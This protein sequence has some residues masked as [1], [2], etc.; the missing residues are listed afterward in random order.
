MSELQGE[1]GNAVTFV[2]DLHLTRIF[3][4]LNSFYLSKHRMQKM[5][6]CRSY[7]CVCLLLP[8]PIDKE[9]SERRGLF[10]FFSS[11]G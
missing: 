8:F 11:N 3:F 2:V 7:E 9:G 1:L 6:L 10:P 4:Y 5:N